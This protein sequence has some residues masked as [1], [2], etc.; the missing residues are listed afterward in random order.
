MW[1]EFYGD[2]R[3]THEAFQEWRRSNVDGFHMTEGAAGQF[4]IHYTQDQRENAARRGCSHQGGSDNEYLQD[5]DSCYTTAK[6][7]C[8]NDLADLIAWA[9]DIRERRGQRQFRDALFARYGKR[10]M[11]T[12]CQILA[13]LEAAHI[14]PYRGEN[15][16]HPENGLL[17]RSD[18]HTLFDLDL[19]GIAPDHLQ[20]VLHPEVAKEYGRF[21][22]VSLAC[23]SERRPSHEALRLRFDEFQRRLCRPA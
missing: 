20:V 14:S 22:D 19:I 10:C 11:V 6:K 7:V 18:I 9:K 8:S 5:K 2:D 4:T 13:V 17:L 21:A 23:G 1:K 3:K 16:N 12:G 15:D